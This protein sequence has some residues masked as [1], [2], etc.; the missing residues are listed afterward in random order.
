MSVRT[1]AFGS[2]FMCFLQSGTEGAYTYKPIAGQTNC[3]LSI[4]TSDREISNKNQGAWKNFAKGL[5]GWSASVDIDLTDDV[6][7]NEVSWEDLEADIITRAQKTYVFAWVDTA[8][9]D[10][11]ADT[12]AID[13]TK[14]M[15]KGLAM[16]NFP[17]NAPHGENMNTSVTL[18]GCLELEKVETT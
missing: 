13:T 7:A 17:I 16:I 12:P 6:N 18:Q 11:S 15:W 10:S 3:S 2:D 8:S 1:I 5:L 4:E 14:P 9:F